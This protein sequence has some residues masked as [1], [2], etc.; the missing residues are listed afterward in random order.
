MLAERSDAG[1]ASTWFLDIGNRP[2]G[3][4]H[5]C[6]SIAMRPR[7]S[8]AQLLA[9]MV[10]IAVGL[11]AI[12]SPSAFWEGTVFVLMLVLFFAAI[13]GVIYRK[14][15]ERAFWLGFALFGWGFCVLRSDVS[16]E[17]RFFARPS[18]TYY[19]ANAEEQEHPVK[20]LTRSLLDV[21]RPYR[22]IGPQSAGERVRVQWG[23]AGSY[24][25]CSVLEIKDSKYKIRYDND[26][27][28]VYDE[29]VGIERIKLED[30]DRSYRIGELLLAVLFAMVGA[31]IAR[32]FYASRET[33]KVDKQPERTS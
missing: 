12:A 15:N 5:Y 31:V 13:L 8:I 21:L 10:P 22:T 26:S 28:G 7:I 1:L 6:E 17:F 25:P 29:W 33:R 18:S 9:V 32:C 11:A 24:Y 30:L 19:W 4:G 2:P 23:G 20:A 27:Q 14:N 16:L 3:V